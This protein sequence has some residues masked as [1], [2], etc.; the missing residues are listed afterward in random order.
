M[1]PY[2]PVGVWELVS[3]MCRMAEWSPQVISTRLRSGY[4]RC[5]LGAQF[6]NRNR[7]GELE[8]TTHAE[9][10]RFAAERELAFQI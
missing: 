4:H 10:V 5:E 7:H 8:W 9:I 6:T 2:S 3:D 1:A